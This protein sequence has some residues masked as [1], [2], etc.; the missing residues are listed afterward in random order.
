MAR[1]GPQT[2]PEKTIFGCA[3]S[4][5]Q[6]SA[7][8]KDRFTRVGCRVRSAMGKG[9]GRLKI[10]FTEV[11]VQ[12]VQLRHRGNR[13]TGLVAF[14]QYLRLQPGAMAPTRRRFG[15]HR[16]PPRKVGGHHR[17]RPLRSLQDGTPSRLQ[18][19]SKSPLQTQQPVLAEPAR[20]LVFAALLCGLGNARTGPR[21]AMSSPPFTKE[22]V[23]PFLVRFEEL[24][25]KETSSWSKTAVS[26]RSQPSRW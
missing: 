16:C 26:Q 13:R 18:V 24:A 7:T 9:K 15:V 4:A 3:V 25:E 22:S 2:A 19:R 6:N 20:L 5:Q 11:R 10:L 8:S 17:H 21:S 1:D 23:E 14:T 12:A